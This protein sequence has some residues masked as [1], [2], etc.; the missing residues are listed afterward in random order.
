MHYLKP[1]R[2]ERPKASVA[3]NRKAEAE[4]W[5]HVY[6]MEC[7]DQSEEGGKDEW[8]KT[9]E[10]HIAALSRFARARRDCPAD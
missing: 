2:Y 1:T 7:E 8:K 5:R 6:G 4:N 3:A 10:S 9:Q